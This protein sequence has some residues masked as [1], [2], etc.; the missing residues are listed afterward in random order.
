NRYA[1]GGVYAFSRI[2]AGEPA[3][4]TAGEP[5]MS[6]AD[7][8]REYV[9]ALN[10]SEQAQT[11]PIPTYVAKRD[12]QR[13]YGQGAEHVKSAEDATLTL[14]VPPLSALVY[15]SSGRIPQSKAAPTVTLTS[16]APPA[17]TNSRIQVTADVPGSSF[18]E[19]T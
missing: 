18:Y 7:D 11:A 19:V 1:A 3:M 6:T 14:T 12:F 10:N 15:V 16:A 8:Q 13:L 2:T 5:A 4:P 9:V 17:G